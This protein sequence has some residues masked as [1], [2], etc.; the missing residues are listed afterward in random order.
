MNRKL[1]LA[2]LVLSLAVVGG[3]K[4]QAQAPSWSVGGAQEASAKPPMPS[5][6]HPSFV[7]AQAPAS[8][9][10]CYTCGND[11]PVYTGAIPTASAA[12][13]YGPSCSGTIS[14]TL[15]DHIPYHCAR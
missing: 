14:T 9:A 10:I 3:T 6:V 5:G 7:N 13:E 2:A 8:S 11:W 12:Y 1:S 4:A 15:N